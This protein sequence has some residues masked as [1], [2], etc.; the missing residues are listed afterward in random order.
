MTVFGTASPTKHEEVL[1]NGVNYPLKPDVYLTDF[2]RTGHT[3]VDIIIDNIGGDNIAKSVDLL[4]PL[5]HLIITGIA[6]N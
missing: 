4:N 6:C 2:N 1:K 3:G 5:G